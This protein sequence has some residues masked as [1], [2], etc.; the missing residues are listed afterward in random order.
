MINNKIELSGI[1]DGKNYTDNRIADSN[2]YRNQSFSFSLTEFFTSRGN[3]QKRTNL[4]IFA[5]NDEYVEEVLNLLEESD[6]GYNIAF[7]GIKD[8]YITYE[9]NLNKKVEFDEWELM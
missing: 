1:L 3:T 8:K 7:T 4:F 6:I 2:A 5:L 9:V